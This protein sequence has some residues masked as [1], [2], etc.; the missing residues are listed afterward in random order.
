VH[1]SVGEDW[2]FDAGLLDACVRQSL[3]WKKQY[4]FPEEVREILGNGVSSPAPAWQ[5]IVV[6]RPERQPVVLVLV[7]MAA[8]PPQL[9]GFAVRQESWHVEASYPAFTLHNDWHASFPGLADKPSDAACRQAWQSWCQ[10]RS[11]PGE[12][13][14]A[15]ILV[16]DGLHLHVKAPAALVE[17]LRASRSDALKG[18]AWILVGNGASRAA[19]LLDITESAE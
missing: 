13:V 3:A 1:F 11:L 10:A 18:E 2:H 8:A 16:P 4:G 14:E 19:L 5:R 17:R 15:C 6:D 7:G 9:Q 12:E